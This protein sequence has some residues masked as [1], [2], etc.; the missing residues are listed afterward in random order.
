MVDPVTMRLPEAADVVAPDGILVR[1][2][3]QLQGGSMAHFELPAGQVS[4]AVTHRT[5]E[6]I[7][8]VLEGRG[9]MW[10]RT[11][12]REEVTALEPGVSVT[13]PLGTAFQ[14][15]SSG[16]GSLTAV[17]ITMPPWPGDGEAVHVE[18]RWEP[19]L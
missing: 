6:E 4:R 15:R 2:L 7:W 5:V 17:A 18:G 11:G 9:E 14:F 3:P 10:R 19:A 1:L 8:L 13:I 12:D 16:P